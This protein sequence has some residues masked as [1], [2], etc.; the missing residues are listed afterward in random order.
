MTRQFVDA[1]SP[2]NFA[3]TNPEVMKRAIATEGASLVQGL[4]TSPPTRS[5][6]ASR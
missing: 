1:M 4:P 5:A 6:A 3:A 2:T